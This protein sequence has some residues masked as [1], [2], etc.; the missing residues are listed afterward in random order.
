LLISLVA[1]VVGCVLGLFLAW[2]MV[3][4]FREFGIVS[5]VLTLNIGVRP[6]LTSAAVL[7][8]VAQGASWAASRSALRIRPGDALSGSGERSRHRLRTWLQVSLGVLLLIAAGSLQ[9]LGMA[10]LVPA[11]LYASYGM[12]A[13]IMVGVGLLGSWIIHAFSRVLRHPVAAISRVGGHLASANV[14]FHH[15]RFVGVAAPLAVGVAIAGWALSGLPLFALSNADQVLERFE[16]DH[17]L[18][19]PVVRDEPMG[20]SE[21]TRDRVAEVEG[22]LATAG[23][24]ETWAHVRAAGSEEP[25]RA[26]ET[27]R[28]TLVDGEASRVLDLGE[29]GGDLSGVDTGEGVAVGATYAQDQ[30]L[31]L[32]DEV[33]MRISGATEV[34]HQQV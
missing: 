5:S 26:G 10:G 33:E 14:R 32:G 11:V 8:L 20:L 19:T 13:G 15:R 34:S 21:A 27:T 1:A 25:D 18:H 31:E 2:G 12:I 30:G 4:L 24:R 29:V 23:L 9:A 6:L 22:V 17:V 3:G 16:A 28:L 7:V